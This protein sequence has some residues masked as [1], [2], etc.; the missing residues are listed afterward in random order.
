MTNL[1]LIKELLK[2]R[3]LKI[4]MHLRSRMEMSGLK[5]ILDKHLV[6]DHV[7]LQRLISDHYEDAQ[8]D[9]LELMDNMKDEIRM[10]FSDP[11]GCFDAILANTEG[12]ALDFFSSTLKHLLLV[13]TDFDTRMRYFQ[14]VEKL[15]SA[16]VTDRKGFD[17]D[18]SA[19]LGSSVASVVALF[20]DQDRLEVALEDL[21]DARNKI[22]RLEREKETIRDRLEEGAAEAG[23]AGAASTLKDKVDKLDRA[24]VLSRAATD[25]TKA[26]LATK[27]REYQHQIAALRLDNRELYERLKKAGMLDGIADELQDRM[28]K[29]LQRM[30]TVQIL[31]GNAGG[32]T[33]RPL[34]KPGPQMLG[35]SSM[36][37]RR[38]T[39][40]TEEERGNSLTPATPTSPGRKH[41]VSSEPSLAFQVSY[42]D[43]CC[44]TGLCVVTESSTERCRSRERA[45]THFAHRSRIRLPR[46]HFGNRLLS[47]QTGAI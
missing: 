5:R 43:L 6:L 16:V 12:R 28:E 45:Q 23:A 41:L 42:A 30:R 18:F 27:E 44:L 7:L 33:S 40:Q 8:N 9:E 4:R 35:S 2:E 20:G 24:L 15:V 13:P 38:E 47:A 21:E 25:T 31:E 11:R 32:E 37:K 3:D 10:N 17:G 22:K 1:L 19:L 29:Q 14:L 26:E 36:R 46:R 39:G 34:S